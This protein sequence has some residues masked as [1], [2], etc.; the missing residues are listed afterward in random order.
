MKAY[1]QVHLLLSN[2]KRQRNL[3]LPEIHKFK[4]SQCNE[5]SLLSIEDLALEV[6]D[7]WVDGLANSY[8]QTS[9]YE[10]TQLLVRRFLWYCLDRLNS[11]VLRGVGGLPVDLS[12]ETGG[13]DA[14]AYEIFEDGW[15]LIND[16]W[17]HVHV[18]APSQDEFNRQVYSK[19]VSL[20]IV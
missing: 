2:R 8:P 17:N 13:F 6:L 4:R 16:W 7:I 3:P 14:W 1:L 11:R 9:N 18:S 12:K 15:T 20:L 5:S 19:L 10:P